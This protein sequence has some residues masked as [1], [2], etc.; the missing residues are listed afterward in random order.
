MGGLIGMMLA[1]KHGAPIRRLVLNDVVRSSVGRA[2]PLK[3]YITRGKRFASVLEVETYLREVCAPFGPLTTSSASTWRA[4]VRGAAR[5]ASSTC[6]NDPAIGGGCTATSI[7]NFPMG[8]RCCAASTCWSVW[9]KVT[10]PVL[11]LRGADSEVLTRKTLDEMRE[12]SP[13][14]RASNPGRRPRAGA[15]ERRPDR[16]GQALPAQVMRLLLLLFC[17]PALAAEPLARAA[18]RGERRHHLRGQRVDVVSS[19]PLGE[20]FQ[21]RRARHRRPQAG[22]HALFKA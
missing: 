3:G 7:R 13:T 14:S 2:V 11:V 10:C 5:T 21:S 15:D 12:R 20:G 8:R 4:T 1:A 9:S 17:L 6:A 16:G 18:G 22:R 19:Q